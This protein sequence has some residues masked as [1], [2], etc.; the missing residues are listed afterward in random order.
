MR[1][2]R[3]FVVHRLGV[4][5]LAGA[6]SVAALASCGQEAGEAPALKVAL[7]AT[8]QISDRADPADEAVIRGELL[9]GLKQRYQ[10]YG[11]NT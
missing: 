11:W 8:V 4:G 9:C 5:T 7:P 6:S 2:T 1:L 10:A 3:R